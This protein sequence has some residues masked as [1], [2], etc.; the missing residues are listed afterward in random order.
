TAFVADLGTAQFHPHAK[1]AGYHVAALP[2]PNVEI[3]VEVID[4]M[5][6]HGGQPASFGDRVLDS[7]PI[8]DVLR[9]NSDF[10]FSNKMA[11]ADFHWRVPSWRGFELYAEGAIDDFDARRLESV[12]LEDGGYL[13]GLSFTCLVQCGTLGARV[14]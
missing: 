10:Q 1:L 9:A 6:G 5:G 11:G 4:A 14:E 13:A 7:I 12:L 2:A 3:G 8:F